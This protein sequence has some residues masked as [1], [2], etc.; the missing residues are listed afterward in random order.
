M[1]SKDPNPESANGREPRRTETGTGT[2]VQIV[3]FPRPRP[4]P[5]PSSFLAAVGYFREIQDTVST[6]WI[7]MLPTE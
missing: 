3:K 2:R 7:Y 6:S 5:S 4:I 1:L